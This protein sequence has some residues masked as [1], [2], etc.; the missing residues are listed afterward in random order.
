MKSRL[1]RV[2]DVEYAWQR[3]QPVR[4]PASLPRLRAALRSAGFSNIRLRLDSDRESLTFSMSRESRLRRTE[5]DKLLRLLI[6][7]FR[8][9]GFNAGFEELALDQVG[10]SIT[11]MTL[12]GALAEVAMNGAPE[13]EGA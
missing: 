2:T 1:R 13:I 8:D 10:A 12:T 5:G 4:P 3:R 11:G 7:A 6:R 9:G